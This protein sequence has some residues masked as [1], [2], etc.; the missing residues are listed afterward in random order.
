MNIH[1]EKLFELFDRTS[2]PYNAAN[3]VHDLLS[4]KKI[5]LYGAGSGFV[6]FSV[7]VLEKYGLKAYAILD[8]KFKANNTYCKIPAFSPVQYRPTAEEKETAV[9]IITV[10]K[11]EYHDEIFQ[12]LRDLGFKNIL[13][14]NDLYEYHLHYA[15]E[16]IEKKGIGYYLE[17]KEKIINS[18]DL[19]A[20]NLSLE[21]FSRVIETHLLRKPLRIPCNILEEQY[22]PKDI[23]LNKGYSRFINCGAYNG[24]TIKKLNELFG[25]INA[26][27]CFEPDPENFELL[28][29]YLNN[30]KNKIAQ[31]VKAFPYGVFSHEIQLHFAG[32]NKINS[33]ISDK[34]KSV[35]QCVALDHV[36][37]NF[38]PTFVSM[39]IEGA[40]FEA[41]KGSE[42]LIKRSKPDLAIC[43]YHMPN[44]IWD[45]PFY[46]HSLCL[47]YRF[48]L[49]NYTSFIAETVLYATTAKEMK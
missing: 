12:C 22:F 31:S 48:Y 30:N 17:N 5:I 3:C 37:P 35:V 13:L 4:N 36:I 29:Q 1:K 23:N 28:T 49:R 43:V 47:G 44:H 14:A 19:F 6:T 16:E 40:E 18:I 25:R 39:D 7:F 15:S 33:A 24:D 20:D 27:A 9:I 38:N 46:L 8:H 26:L 2:F 32:G 10:G 11:K 34:G 45:I 41:L 21:I 42:A